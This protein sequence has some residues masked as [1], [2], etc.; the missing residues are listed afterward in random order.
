MDADFSHPEK[1]SCGFKNIR[2][3]VDGALKNAFFQDVDVD[4]ESLGCTEH[5]DTKFEFLE[6]RNPCKSA[7]QSKLFEDVS[8]PAGYSVPFVY[9]ISCGRANST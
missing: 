2:I 6:R 9:N 3:R 8:D 5:F 4:P 1:K 7:F